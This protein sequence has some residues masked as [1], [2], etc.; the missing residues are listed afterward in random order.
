[1]KRSV[2]IKVMKA[3]VIP[4]ALATARARSWD[5]FMIRRIE[6][7]V[8]A[9]LRRCFG[10]TYQTLRDYRIS[11]DM[12]RRAAGWPT[13]RDMVM[14]TSLRWLGHVS[15][16]KI[17]RRPK[18]MLFGWW[19]GRSIKYNT[20][21]AQSKWLERCLRTSNV[22]ISVGDWFRLA[23]Q[24]AEWRRRVHKPQRKKSSR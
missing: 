20:W 7:L 8:L 9:S 13:I 17:H 23:E 15:R 14:R 1:M 11:N 24:R 12:L 5:T 16:M 22:S 4:S 2:R 21:G 10:V 19:K 3:V 18:Q 6:Q